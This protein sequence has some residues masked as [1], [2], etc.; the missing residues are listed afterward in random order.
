VPLSV[1]FTSRKRSTVSGIKTA[2]KA[3]SL[4]IIIFIGF[5]SE[6]KLPSVSVQCK[7][8]KHLS[9]IASMMTVSPRWYQEVSLTE[10]L[11]PMVV[12]I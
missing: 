8:L 6:K 9:G 2:T 4:N 7:K 11:P 12:F 10:V 1:K 3:E 5:S